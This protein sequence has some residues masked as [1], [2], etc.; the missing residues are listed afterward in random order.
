MD[1][2][3]WMTHVATWYTKEKPAQVLCFAAMI[4]CKLSTDY[5]IFWLP[6]VPNFIWFFAQLTTLHWFNT[7]T[8]ILHFELDDNI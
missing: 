7:T 6:G 3:P 5:A 8:L 1:F 2:S 4:V